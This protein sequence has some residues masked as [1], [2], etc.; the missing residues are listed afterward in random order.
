MVWFVLGGGHDCGF[1]C[2]F[3]WLRAGAGGF[4]VD[5]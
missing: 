2:V 5:L 3:W 4:G 1:S